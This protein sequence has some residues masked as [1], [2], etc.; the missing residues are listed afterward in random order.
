VKKP[1]EAMSLD[2]LLKF[3]E[4]LKQKDIYVR[5]LIERRKAE[6]SSEGAQ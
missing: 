5:W 1:L 6:I 3:D 4:W 2:E